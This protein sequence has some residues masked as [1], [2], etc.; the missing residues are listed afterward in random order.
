MCVRVDGGASMSEDGGSS[1]ARRAARI[2]QS[3]AETGIDEAMIERLVRAFYERAPSSKNV[4]ILV[5]GSSD[6]RPL[7]RSADAET[8]SAAG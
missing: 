7:S 2:E 3:R 8:L 5:I 6:E 4:R 1:Q